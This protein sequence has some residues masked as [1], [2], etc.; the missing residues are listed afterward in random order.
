MNANFTDRLDQ[1]ENQE[2]ESNH[3]EAIFG[4]PLI[5]LILVNG[6]NKLDAK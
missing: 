4:S 6:F 3:Q 1:K 2:R 5:L